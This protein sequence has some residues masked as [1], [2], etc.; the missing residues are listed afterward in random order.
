MK[1]IYTTLTSLLVLASAHIA[2]ADEMPSAM[3]FGPRETLT[4]VSGDKT[5]SFNIEVADTRAE[6]ARGYMF[7]DTVAVDEGM[8]FEF[9]EVEVASIWMK[10]TSVFLDVLF[11]QP[12]GSILKIEHSAKPYSLRSMTSEA[13]VAAVLE[14][15]GGQTNARGIKAGDIVQHEFFTSKK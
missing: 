1:K 3:N 7:R 10:N 15:A 12:N 2:N 13:P 8:L 6:R 14:L 11:V 4:I 9:E 5:H